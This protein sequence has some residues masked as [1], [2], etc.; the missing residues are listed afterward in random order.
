MEDEEIDFDKILE[1]GPTVGVGRGVGWHAH[2]LAIEG[3]QPPV[4]ENPVFLARKAANADDGAFTDTDEAAANLSGTTVK[5]LVKHVLSR[6]L[7][8]Y[9]ERL[10][11]SILTPPSEAKAEENTS[12]PSDDTPL[13]D[14][15]QISSGN[16]VRDAAL[17]S[18]RGDAGIHQLVPYLVQWVGSNVTHALRTSSQNPSAEKGT[19]DRLNTVHLLHTML[20]TLH[21][22]LINPSIFIE[23]YVCIVLSDFSSIN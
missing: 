12:L 3:I 4:P 6:E 11:S 8:L 20:S 15:A 16:L 23:P 1:H 10:T 21:A 19:S 9:Y 13:G 17:A 2:W 22:L 7:Q 14:Y 18:L 5:P